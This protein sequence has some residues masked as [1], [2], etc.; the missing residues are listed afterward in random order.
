MR[1]CRNMTKFFTDAA[2]LL[3]IIAQLLAAGEMEESSLTELPYAAAPVDNPLKGLVPYSGSSAANRFPHSMEFGYLPLGDLMKGEQKFDWQPL[4]KLLNAAAGRGHQLT[5][6]IWIEYPGRTEG[7]PEFLKKGGLKVVDWE[8]TNTAPFPVKNILTPDYEDPKLIAALESFIDAFGRKYDGD[9]RIAC[10]TAGLLGAWGEWHTYPRPELMAS[11]K[12]Q[13]RVLKAYADAFKTTQVLLRYP[14]DKHNDSYAANDELPLGYHD[15]SFAWG[16]LDTGKADDDWFYMSL[17]G[18]AGE[19]AKNKWKRQMIGG[20]VRPEV[21]AIIFDKSVDHAQA[22]DFDECVRQ[23]HVSWLLETGMFSEDQPPER[24]RRAK[25]KVARMGYEFHI[26]KVGLR[27]DQLTVVIRNTGVA[28]FYYDWPVELAEL[29][30]EAPKIRRI[31]QA[32]WKITG[33]LPGESRT[34]K[35]KLDGE[36]GSLAIRIRNP[37]KGGKP[38]RFANAKELQLN[39]GWLLLVE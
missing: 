16:T 35:L 27:D 30:A 15:D 6:R 2:I 4:E 23:T 31:W 33:I 32:A 1:I 21:W 24:V 18:A 19:G 38:L 39:S 22:Q 3:L 25:A 7:I 28:P 11:K 20:E 10:I 26:A 13:R 14:A 37:M 12:V 29:A 17:L 34:W 5:F 8:Y 36:V 9:P